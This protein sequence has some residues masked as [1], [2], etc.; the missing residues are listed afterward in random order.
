MFSGQHHNYVRDTVSLTKGRNTL[1]QSTTNSSD[2]KQRCGPHAS[3]NTHGGHHIFYATTPP[4][5]QNVPNLSRARHAVGVAN[6]NGA[7]IHVV[8]FGIDPKMVA[9][10]QNLASEGFV[11]LPKANVAHAKTCSLQQL[12]NGIDRADTHLFR[13]VSCNCHT[14]IDT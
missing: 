9:A 8:D 1:L 6:R 13:C 11:E 10:I 5:K 4:L 12:W 14:A 2:F 7:A 3:A